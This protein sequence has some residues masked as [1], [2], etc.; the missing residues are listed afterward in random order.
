MKQTFC[1]PGHNLGCFFSVKISIFSCYYTHIVLWA[2]QHLFQTRFAI[3]LDN[4]TD[5]NIT[6]SLSKTIGSAGCRDQWNKRFGCMQVNKVPW[7]CGCQRAFSLPYYLILSWELYQT[8]SRVYVIPHNH[9]KKRPL[10]PGYIH[11]T[12]IMHIKQ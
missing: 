7:P 11:S 10:E 6:M 4:N 5:G 2:D 8:V 1:L 12:S 9:F 3:S